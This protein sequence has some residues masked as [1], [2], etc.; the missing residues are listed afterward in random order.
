M[1]KYL[2]TIIEESLI[3]KENISS[4]D[5]TQSEY[6][7]LKGQLHE[8]LYEVCESKTFYGVKLNIVDKHIEIKVDNA[9]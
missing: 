3:K 6:Q 4:I 2:S 9:R 1:I 5:I 8:Q 7:K